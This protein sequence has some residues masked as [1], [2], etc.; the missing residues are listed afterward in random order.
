MSEAVGIVDARLVE[1][2]RANEA[3]LSSELHRVQWLLLMAFDLHEMDERAIRS[4]RVERDILA[5]AARSL[6]EAVDVADGPEPFAEAVAEFDVQV[7]D[8]LDEWEAHGG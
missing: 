4:A 1:I 5:S 7:R 8:M 2:V 3:F 6:L